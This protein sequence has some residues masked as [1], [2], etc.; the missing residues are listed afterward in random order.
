MGCVYPNNKGEYAIQYNQTSLCLRQLHNS[1]YLYY[2][3]HLVSSGQ[4]VYRDNEMTTY[5]KKL[6][7]PSSKAVPRAP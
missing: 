6:V 5:T 7:S 3:G 1:V 4:R 2:L